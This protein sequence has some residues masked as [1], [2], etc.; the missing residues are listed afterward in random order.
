MV[1]KSI[2]KHWAP[3]CVLGLVL[4][5]QLGT[6]LA[7]PERGPSFGLPESLF[8]VEKGVPSPACVV[9]GYRLFND[10]KLSADGST[11]CASC[12][13][14]DRAFSDGLPVAIGQGG[15]RGIRNAPSLLNVAWQTQLFW[16]GRESEL[17]T[18]AFRPLLNSFEHGLPDERA[19]LDTLQRDR[20]YATLFRQAFPVKPE[21]SLDGLGRAL[22]CYEKTLVA[23]DSP[24]DRYEYA[25]DRNALSATAIRGLELFRGRAGCATCHLIESKSAM[26]SDGRFHRRGISFEVV[27]SRLAEAL[28][29]LSGSGSTKDR[30][31]VGDSEVSQ[32]GRF[33][34]SGDP[35][36]IGSFKTPSLRNVALTA[37]YMHDGSV[38]TLE[39]AVVL[40]AYY[41]L[42]DGA[43]PIVLSAREIQDIVEFLKSLT[44]PWA[45]SVGR[46]SLLPPEQWGNSSGKKTDRQ[47][48]R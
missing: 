11:S 36:D 46:K 13:R 2:R 33:A 35:S 25:A 41:G 6:A 9:L 30:L 17:A 38:E 39:R 29:K 40:E 15:Q 20:R 31:I 19:I 10:R 43:K 42:S 21:I 26:F 1:W 7:A 27:Q 16:D 44:S 14:S 18:Q 22:A 45:D 24:F 48:L 5:F 47:A 32:L 12:H 8:R 23:A 3:T 4:Q 37:P 28:N 34:V